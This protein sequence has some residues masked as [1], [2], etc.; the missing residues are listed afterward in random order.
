MN[1]PGRR[2][3][4]WAVAL[5]LLAAGGATAGE[6][7]LFTASDF[8]AGPVRVGAAETA[9]HDVWV[10]T[11]GP[12]KWRLAVDGP[13]LRLTADPAE[14]GKSKP[15]WVKVGSASLFADQPATF[16]VGPEGQEAQAVPAFLAVTSD[17]E[18]DRAGAL[19]ILR[20]DP[21]RLDPPPDPRRTVVRSNQQGARFRPP[22]TAQA[23]HDRARNL[24]EQL[25]VTL[26]LWPMPPKTDLHP[27]V[28]PV[29][30]REGY[31][32][33]RVVL[34]TLPGFYLAGN[35]FRPSTDPGPAGPRRPLILCPHGHAAK[36]RFDS[37][38]Q[39]RCAHLARLGA[40]VFSYDMVGFGDSKPFGHAFLSDRLRRWGLS[41]ATL[42]TWNSI[43]ALD[44]ATGRPDVDP[45]RVGVTGESGGGTQTFLLA[46][47]DDRVQAAAPVVMVSE[48]FQG[49]CVCENAAGLRL[50]TD[51]VEIAA[52]TAPRPMKLVGATGDWTARTLTATQPNLQIVYALNGTPDRFGAEV[53]D[54]GHQYNQTSR[55]AVYPFFARWLIPDAPASLLRETESRIEPIAT[56][57]AYG[58]GH[59]YPATARTAEDL[60]AA[61]VATVGARVDRLAPDPDAGPWEAA[62]ETLRVAHRVRLPI[63]V[64]AARDLQIR[65]VRRDTRG[66]GDAALEVTHQTVGRQAVGEEIPIVRIDPA[67][68]TGQVVV[69]AT[70]RGKA[71][72]VGKDGR[73]EPTVRALL[74]RGLSVVGFDPLLV[75]E[76]VDPAKPQARRP[77]VV[78]FDT[79]N[80]SLAADRAQD[81][82]T[83]V[84]WA[85]TLPDVRTVHLV[86]T[87]GM[88]P[89]ALLA[90]PR[91]GAM[92]RTLADLDG[93]DVVDGSAPVPPGLDLPG[94]LQFGGLKGA[95][96]LAAPHP[97]RVVGAPKTFDGGWATRAYAGLD[98]PGRFRLDCEDVPPA[99]VA[100][101]IAGGD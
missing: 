16:A 91:L 38:T 73:P 63:E 85:R 60:E 32:I 59:H 6:T 51:N 14:G 97:L 87:D 7:T 58:D 1:R 88:G 3:V 15:A 20:G 39:A 62:R 52:L 80:P 25:R 56:L 94:L 41:L 98:A 22:D 44:W 53:F 64:P 69:V 77:E 86:A 49:G 18:W 36:G 78:H 24:R 65:L 101:W 75:G 4:S 67:R 71:A 99:E 37:D 43:R 45:A 96:A 11:S 54:F 79:Y 81:L 82:A 89:L 46:A 2:L 48:A 28:E 29:A 61:L 30:E 83:V 31:A 12:V 9:P 70:G 19:D 21:S 66:T 50:G 92:G 26:G 42:Q 55:N 13:V 27:Q 93:F 47:L 72:L 90:R 23:W 100:A 76:S 10:W 35:L 17:P 40:V 74:D 68:R 5:A 57:T 95:A 33:D 8:A 34:E 84:A